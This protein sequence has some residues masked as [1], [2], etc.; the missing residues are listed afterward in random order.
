M[1]VREKGEI[2]KVLERDLNVKVENLFVSICSVF[3][4]NV[5]YVFGLVGG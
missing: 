1:L 3:S 4:Y 2:F 5:M